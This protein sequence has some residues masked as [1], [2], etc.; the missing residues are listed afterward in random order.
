MSKRIFFRRNQD[1]ALPPVLS[2][3]FNRVL[4]G[5]GRLVEY[6]IGV[7]FLRSTGW[8]SDPSLKGIQLAR[9]FWWA[10][11]KLRS[12]HPNVAKRSSYVIPESVLSF[13][14]GGADS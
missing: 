14:D 10:D 8:V 5:E 6:F 9:Q 13:C 2:A 12:T 7:V 11:Y 3:A 1:R 4:D